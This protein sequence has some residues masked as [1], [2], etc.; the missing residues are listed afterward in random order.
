MCSNIRDG[1]IHGITEIMEMGIMESRMLE[2]IRKG[3]RRGIES[4]CIIDM[5]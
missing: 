5:Q 2:V 4:D 3:I 1:G